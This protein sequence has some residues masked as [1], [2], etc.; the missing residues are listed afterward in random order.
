M[1]IEISY[2]FILG[3]LLVVASIV[4]LNI[5]VPLIGIPEHLQQV[6]TVGCALLVGLVLGWIFSKV[7]TSSIRQLSEA[8]DRLRK[9]DLSRNIR[10]RQKWFPDET[11][12]LS[13]S[14]NGVVDSLRELVG[15]IRSTSVKTAESAQSLSAT[16]QEVTASAHEV[17]STVEQISNGAETQAMLTEKSSAMVKEMAM[18]IDLVASSA[19]KVEAAASDTVEN[20]KHGGDVAD[21]AMEKM[22]QVFS[23]VEESG[24]RLVEFGDQLQ[25]I[26]QIVEVITGIANKTNL[27]ALN[28]TI[29]AARAGEYGRGFAVVA[30]EVRKLADSTSESA[31]EITGLINSIR[32][33]SDKV[34]QTIQRNMQE[35]E[36]GNEAIDRTGAAFEKII[37][38]ALTTQD[39]A[40]SIADLAGKQ[41]EGSKS[42][43][44]A[45]EEISNVV[46]DSAAAVQEVSAATEEQSASMEE[47]AKQ[48]QQL[49]S[50]GEELLD[51]VS[52]FHLGSKEE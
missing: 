32:D 14:L 26:G 2:K 13:T 41:T 49:S 21:Q 7:F 19:K 36:D 9:G 43:V 46:T 50:L 28:A 38:T 24:K 17:A 15:Y 42:V 6:V 39:K 3:F 34:I 18:S 35:V 52:R 47:L 27:L 37:Q 45:I 1:R 8:A 16:S 10:L 23:G 22:R 48:A 31:G 51:M 25:Q 5:L 12:D 29:E 33:E 44:S 30:E 11:D 40:N 20:A 4:G